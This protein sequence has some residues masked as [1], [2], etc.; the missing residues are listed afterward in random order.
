[1]PASQPRS[2]SSET[3][4][5]DGAGWQARLELQFEQRAGRTR[6]VRNVH[7]GPLRL[8]RALQ[9]D[10]G[11]TCHAVIVHPPGG[12][13]AGDALALRM[14]L[15]DGAR[16]LATTPGAQKWYRA[17]AGDATTT[18]RISAGAGAVLEWLPQPAIVFDAASVQ[19]TVS[20]DL[21]ADARA[22]GWECLVLGRGAMGERFR[23]GLLRQRLE[24][25]VG[26]RTIWAEQLAARAGERL[27]ESPL[28][29]GGATVAASLWIVG[30]DREVGERLVADLREH[31]DG[32][33]TCRCGVTRLAPGVAVA[34]ILAD[35]SEQAMGAAA[36]L[37]ALARP[38]VLGIAATPP[39]IWAT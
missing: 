14:R 1:M 31:A 8:I 4:P 23:R 32:L 19:Q 25:R 6:L 3:G 30:A 28:G 7:Q 39:R 16:V 11:L 21:A 5:A 13:V 27:F 22:L 9:T 18:V 36:A 35:D 38:R 17:E 15:G 34:K 29:W 20:L 24:L 10:D 12:I 33:G 26:G 2:P 37:W